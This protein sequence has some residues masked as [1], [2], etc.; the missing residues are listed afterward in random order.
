MQ[1]LIQKR[2]KLQTEI[3][4]EKVTKKHSGTGNSYKIS[5]N[6]ENSIIVKPPVNRA[7]SGTSNDR[8]NNDWDTISG[9]RQPFEGFISDRKHLK[10]EKINREVDIE[11]A[12]SFKKD[13]DYLHQI[14]YCYEKSYGL[15]AAGKEERIIIAAN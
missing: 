11:K 2:D 7:L 5:S 6:N 3:D 10:Q 14:A 15:K 13:V 8:K 4:G 1:Y 12:F 9:E